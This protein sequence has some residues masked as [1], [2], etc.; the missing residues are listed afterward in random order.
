MTTES[1]LCFRRF[2]KK[3]TEL[4]RLY[5]TYALAMEATAK[6]CA[7]AKSEDFIV[8]SVDATFSRNMLPIT[9]AQFR[10]NA[11]NI[12]DRSRLHLL[13]VC[14]ANLEAYLK[15][16]TL[17]FLIAKGHAASHTSLDQIGTALGRPIL[18]R[19]SLLDPLKYAEALFQVDLKHLIAKW[20]HLYK[21]RCAVAHNGGVVTAR[22]LRDIPALRLP[23]ESL[24][25]LSWSDL[26]SALESADKMVEKIDSAVRSHAVKKA[27]IAKELSYLKEA[28]KLPKI[29]QVWKHLHD[30][31][32]MSGT[33][34]Q[35]RAFVEKEFYR[36]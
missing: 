9:V 18:E 2:R 5:W 26:F 23:L 13:V 33:K 6:L 14:A 12:L 7:T 19:D 28:K 10:E 3:H 25:G 32:G 34:R 8:D 24:L 31:F 20:Q 16:V 11:Q 22:T 1:T 35:F 4:S 17:I 29:A 21:L 36:S 15:E 30:E 27:E